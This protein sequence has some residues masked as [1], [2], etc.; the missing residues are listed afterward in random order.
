ML[1]AG[2]ALRGRHAGAGPVPPV[3]LT[4]ERRGR[5]LD[6]F[7]SGRAPRQRSV[8]VGTSAGS[9]LRV[10]GV[11]WHMRHAGSVTAASA[12]DPPGGRWVIRNGRRA[13][14]AGD[15]AAHAGKRR[16]GR[17]QQPPQSLTVV[18]SR[19]ILR[20]KARLLAG[21]PAARAIVRCYQFHAA[22]SA[23]ELGVS[24]A[25]RRHGR[26]MIADVR[27]PWV[28]AQGRHHLTTN[29]PH[30]R[31]LSGRTARRSGSVGTLVILISSIH[32][33]DPVCL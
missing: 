6:P 12:S 33:S 10:S 13:A 9:F 18:G 1:L 2:G 23:L 19:P 3:T 25:L 15:D 21:S 31:T 30:S 27:R 11:S 14:A 5:V 32:R 22:E 4:K 26:R 16:S 24:V 7:V 28:T 8:G 20:D 29:Q 17:P